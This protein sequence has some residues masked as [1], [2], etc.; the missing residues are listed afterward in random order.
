V[1][2]RTSLSPV[3]EGE[4]W[5]GGGEASGERKGDLRTGV[6]KGKKYMR[7]KKAVLLKV[8]CGRKPLLRERERGVSLPAPAGVYKE[9]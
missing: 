1:K 2:L 9:I 7:Q 5:G 6:K 8:L 3:K 4:C